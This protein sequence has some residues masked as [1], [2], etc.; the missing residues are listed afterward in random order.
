MAERI[1][2]VAAMQGEFR[3]MVPGLE[4]EGW[5]KDDLREAASWM[6][7]SVRAGDGEQIRAWKRWLS[8]THG[9]IAAWVQYCDGRQAGTMARIRAHARI[10]CGTREEKTANGRRA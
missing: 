1:V 10:E 2:T 4:V 8:M 5:S 7:D 9:R 6:A 3:R